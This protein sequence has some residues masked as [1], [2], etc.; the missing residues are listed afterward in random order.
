MP[1]PRKLP[2]SLLARARKGEI[3]RANTTPG[4]PERSAVYRVISERRLARRPG[5][6]AR[7]ALGHEAPGD[8]LPVVSFY[9]QLGAGPTLLEDVTVSRR[10]AR[11][12]GRYLSLVGLLTEGRLAPDAFERRVRSWRPVKILDPTGLRGQVMFASAPAAALNLA[13]RARGEER[14]TWIDSG[15]T[16]PSPRRR[17]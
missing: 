11:R 17:R 2:P 8:V 1:A 10:D 3:T 5:L 12:V 16:R 6:T 7:Q 14:E 15:R 13:E 9:A 4:S